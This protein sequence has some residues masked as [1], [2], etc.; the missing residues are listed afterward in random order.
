MADINLLI[1]KRIKFN[2]GTKPSPKLIVVQ[3]LDKLII[4]DTISYLCVGAQNKAHI[5]DATAI[6]KIY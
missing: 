5:V 2:S 3:V 4:K 6:L 1:G